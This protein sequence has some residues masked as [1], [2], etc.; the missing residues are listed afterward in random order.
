MKQRDLL[1]WKHWRLPPF[2]AA[3]RDVGYWPMSGQIV[4]VTP[5]A[6]PK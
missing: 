3:M 5:V 6:A 4:D 2:D 1:G